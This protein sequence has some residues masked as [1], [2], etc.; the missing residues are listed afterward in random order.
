MS[1]TIPIM[2][3]TTFLIV[4]VFFLAPRLAAASPMEWALAF[5]KTNFS[6]AS[7]DLTEIR[8]VG[9]ERDSIPAI[10]TPQFIPVGD[11]KEIGQL[12]P[13]LR[14]AIDDAVR[15]YPLRILLWHELVNDTINETPILISYCPLCSSGVVFDRRVEGETLVFKNTGLL[16][17]YDT[18]LYDSATE[19]WWQQY[20]GDGLVG[21]H[22]G[23]R[24]KALPSRVQSFAQFKEESPEAQILIPENP[25][26]QDYGKTPYVRMDS[27]NDAAAQFPYPIPEGLLPLDR[28]VVVGNEAWP[29]DRV[30]SETRIETDRVILMWSPG[31]NSVHDTRW[32][33]FGRDIGNVRAWIKTET[34]TEDAVHDTTF[35]FAFAAFRPD[36]TWHIK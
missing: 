8:S 35:A 34:G 1:R 18:V 29:L 14:V 4:A 5:P 2:K 19:S 11:A 3:L 32:I 17:H 33:P 24:L 16:R 31:M 25:D 36:G 9:A 27:R 20:T 13:V 10:L 22:A 15:G 6:N 7:I 26:A 23:K 30:R 21:H 12:E 28:V